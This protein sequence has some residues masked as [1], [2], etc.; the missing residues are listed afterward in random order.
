MNQVIAFVLIV[1]S[2]LVAYGQCSTVSV[3]I[4][5]SDTSYVQLYHAGFF[6]IPSGFAN[7][8][9]WEV[10]TFSGEIVYQDITSG[11]AFEQGLVLFDHS[12]SISD[13]MKA[14]IVI[15]NK[16]EGTIC[17]MND[18]LYW[19]ET[20]I[21]PGSFIGNWDVLS[22][23]GGVEETITSSFEIESESKA[24]K[25]FPSVTHDYIHIESRQEFYSFIIVDSNGRILETF[26]KIKARQKVDITALPI[27]LYFVQIWDEI[28]MY[29][30][31]KKI[32]KY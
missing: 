2:N 19:K 10:T 21:L 30:G 27:G 5:S 26:D 6:N 15:T 9:E 31:T 18:T 1:F 12:I 16:I 24:V 22:S 20:E 7:I 17:T 13:S 29:L 23:N 14:T 3:Q 25:I 32:V 4:S 11:D 28:N 8:C